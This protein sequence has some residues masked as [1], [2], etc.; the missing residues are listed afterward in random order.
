MSS[1]FSDDSLSKTTKRSTGSL[2]PQVYIWVF[3]PWANYK[4]LKDIRH[5]FLRCG[6]KVLL[7]EKLCPDFQR[8]CCYGLLRGGIVNPAHAGSHAGWPFLLPGWN[9][10]HFSTQ[11]VSQASLSSL[12]GSNPRLAAWLLSFIQSFHR[13]SSKGSLWWVNFS[14][15]EIYKWAL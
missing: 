8:G 13:D 4:P 2:F 10:Q 9:L 5:T 14:S 11:G 1:R 3:P 15:R 12:P 6:C 7:R